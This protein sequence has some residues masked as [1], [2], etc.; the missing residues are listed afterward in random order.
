M[1]EV[2]NPTE[3][4]WSSEEKAVHKHFK[5]TITHEEDGKYQVRL[6][7]RDQIEHI[8]NNKSGAIVRHQSLMKRLTR[9]P[10]LGVKYRA[11]IK[12]F[13][14]NGFAEKVDEITEP[15][16]TFY[17]PHH[18]VIKE[19]H[20][21]TKVRPVFEGNASDPDSESLNDSLY[22][23]PTLQPL[24]A[25]VLIRF[26]LNP[27]AFKADVKKMYPMIKVHPEDRD[28][29]R[30]FWEDPDD[31]TMSVY[32]LKVLPFGLSCSPYLAIATVH[33]HLSTYENEYPHIV[34]EL[35]TN[36][37]MD[38]LLSGAES[39]EKAI[40]DYETEVQ[41]MKSSGMELHKFAS[42]HPDLNSRFVSDNVSSPDGHTEIHDEK[43]VLGISWTSDD[44]FTFHE[45]GSL[46]ANTEIQPTKR[47]ILK[48]SGKL[49]DP[50][51]W[52]SPYIV[53]VKMLIQQLWERGLEWDEKL[54]EDLLAKWEYWKEDLGA[55]QHIKFP[56]YIGNHYS[57]KVQPVEL[58]TFGDA[59][60]A[61]PQLPI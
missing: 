37:Y 10:D 8:S 17:S 55:L 12:E 45:K 24:L 40:A 25:A 2:D 31:K 6:P 52:L 35:M 51:G 20:S 21:T 9:N 56:R 57:Q 47:N 32:R 34:K 19:G 61:T 27:I 33:H 50:C 53:L 41:I 13:I 29:L 18:P 5:E 3:T 46:N 22:T 36:T 4:Q 59:S 58:H 54:P 14:D 26:R 39:V 7:V 42:N 60:E 48:I 16:R 15:T 43:A 11:A 49:Y 28:L 30:F 23:G 1:E 38:D 44:Y